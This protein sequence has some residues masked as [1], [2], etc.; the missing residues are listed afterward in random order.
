MIFPNK[1]IKTIYTFLP[2][3]VRKEFRKNCCG[4]KIKIVNGQPIDKISQVCSRE[5][6]EVVFISC[7]DNDE[8]PEGLP[9]ELD[10]L[11]IKYCTQKFID[12]VLSLNNTVVLCIKHLINQELNI[13]DKVEHLNVF[14]PK[15][16]GDVYSPQ[17]LGK[18]NLK[19]FVARNVKFDSVMANYIDSDYVAGNVNCKFLVS[20]GY[21]MGNVHAN[22]LIYYT[23]NPSNIIRYPES[24]NIKNVW[25]FDPFIYQFIKTLYPLANIRLYSP[26]IK[27]SNK[28]IWGFSRENDRHNYDF[29]NLS[30][31]VISIADC[32]LADIEFKKLVPS[33]PSME[34][35]KSLLLSIKSYPERWS[36]NILFDP[37]NITCINISNTKLTTFAG[38]LHLVN[39]KMMTMTNC[40]LKKLRINCSFR[41]VYLNLAS[42]HLEEI[43]GIGLH[44][45]LK[46]LN[47][48]GNNLANIASPSMGFIELKNLITLIITD[49]KYTNRDLLSLL[50]HMPAL[51]ALSAGSILMKSMVLSPIGSM[52]FPNLTGL[53][54]SRL[55]SLKVSY[56]LDQ[57]D[58]SKLDSLELLEL[59]NKIEDIKYPPNIVHITQKWISPNFDEMFKEYNKLHSIFMENCRTGEKI[60]ILRPKEEE[61]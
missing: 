6:L 29:S 25:I 33:R 30:C 55:K 57:L 22:T 3:R 2:E 46:Y 12:K 17:I 21:H 41:L 45:D 37:E 11:T 54:L 18:L 27:I 32:E 5:P 42:N 4:Y 16:G 13:R 40:G 15:S 44:K 31:G 39:L 20:R 9:D 58:I 34:Q 14:S 43:V 36:H 10:I 35:P 52:G 56:C 8:I 53:P 59:N 50:S 47:V 26:I 24:A 60:H 7:G 23:S 61:N 19:T 38:G 51:Q 49:N 28:S 1:I 48:H